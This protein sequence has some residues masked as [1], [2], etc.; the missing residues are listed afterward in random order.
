[1]KFS[2]YLRYCQDA[3]SDSVV[4]VLQVDACHQ[5][6]A[7]V[8]FGKWFHTPLKHFVQVKSIIYPKSHTISLADTK[9]RSWQVQSGPAVCS[10]QREDEFEKVSCLSGNG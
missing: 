6:L 2:L 3:R 5:I 4:F 1:M 10:G 8:L 9:R 7:A